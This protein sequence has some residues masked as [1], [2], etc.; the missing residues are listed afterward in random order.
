M[1][2]SNSALCLFTQNTEKNYTVTDLK[3]VLQDL[4]DHGCGFCGSAPLIR[5]R[6]KNDVS[7][8]ILTANIVHNPPCKGLCP[9]PGTPGAQ[10]VRRRA[11]EWSA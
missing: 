11:E 5:G 9:A 4:V 2:W 1:P 10:P 7:T 3:V 8:G 6:D